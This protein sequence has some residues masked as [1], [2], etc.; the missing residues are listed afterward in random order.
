[1]RDQELVPRACLARPGSCRCGFSTWASISGHPHSCRR[2]ASAAKATFDPPDSS[3]EHAFAEEHP[4][5]G[6]AVDATDERLAVEHLDRMR[7][8]EPVQCAVGAPH[9]VGDPGSALS[10]SGHPCAGG[11]HLVERGIGAD[12]PVARTQ[13]ARGSDST[14]VPRRCGTP[15]AD[16]A[17]TRGSAARREYQGNIPCR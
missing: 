8:T 15:C 14:G 7:V 5:D 3:A 12:R 2:S 9:V 17:T 6:D 10:G 4:A 13:R 11:D 16:P 1:M